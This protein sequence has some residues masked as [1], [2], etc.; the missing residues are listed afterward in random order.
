MSAALAAPIIVTT[1]SAPRPAKTKRFIIKPP[2]LWP[3]TIEVS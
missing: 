1:A 2:S 3:P